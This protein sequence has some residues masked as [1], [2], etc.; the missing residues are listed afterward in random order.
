MREAISIN[1]GLLVL[2]KVMQALNSNS[3]RGTSGTARE[4]VPY[5][6]SKLTRYLQVRRE[7][8]VGG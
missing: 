6:E 7:G 5:R 1:K 8:C 4:H 3:R 2:Q